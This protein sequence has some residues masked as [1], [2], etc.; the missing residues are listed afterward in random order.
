MVAHSHP[1]C[2]QRYSNS[3]RQRRVSLLVI[4]A[5]WLCMRR[6]NVYTQNNAECTQNF[7]ST[8]KWYKFSNFGVAL[9]QYSKN[10]AWSRIYLRIFGRPYYRSSLWYTV[11]SVCLSVVCHL[12]V[13]FCIVAK[14]YI[15][16][17][18]CLK[19]WIGNHGQ[20][21]DILG[22]RHFSTSGFAATATETAVFC[23]M[24]C[25]ETVRPSKKLSEGVNR[26]PGS[27][28]WFFESLPYF[29][30]RFRL[31]GHRDGRFCLIFARTA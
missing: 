9:Q 31:Y 14:R 1:P 24:Y 5:I 6:W 30:F 20:K 7:Q 26:K 4:V 19:E 10:M 13:T 28:S 2:G 15:L 16:A 25:G 22:R 21:V 23:L 3:T 12:S 17:K 11:S 18:N 29:Y 8:L 27:K